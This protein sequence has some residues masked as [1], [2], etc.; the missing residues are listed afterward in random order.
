MTRH[1]RY[2]GSFGCGF[3][4]VIVS[5][6]QILSDIDARIFRSCASPA[7]RNSPMLRHSPGPDSG[8][9]ESNQI[10][11]FSEISS[12][13]FSLSRPQFVYFGVVSHLRNLGNHFGEVFHSLQYTLQDLVLPSA[14]FIFLLSGVV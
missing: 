11:N 14:R 8:D 4:G 6:I 7:A 9:P 2:S 5:C 1:A 10:A 12:S 3:R 13:T